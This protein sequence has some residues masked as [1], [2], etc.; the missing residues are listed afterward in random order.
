M[1]I[2]MQNLVINA[3]RRQLKFHSVIDD[4][5]TA[6]ALGMATKAALFVSIYTLNFAPFTCTALVNLSG[7]NHLLIMPKKL[8]VTKGEHSHTCRARPNHHHKKGNRHC[9][10]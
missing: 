6:R 5:T 9:T 4:F 7:V 8:E 10:L 1:V 2:I 3:C